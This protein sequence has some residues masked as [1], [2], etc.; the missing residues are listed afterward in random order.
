MSIDGSSSSDCQVVFFEKTPFM[1]VELLDLLKNYKII[2]YDDDSVYRHLKQSWDIGSYLNEDLTKE[3]ESDKAV[4]TMLADQ[5]FLSRVLPDR[6]NVSALF[7]FMNRNIDE[8]LRA[9]K[10][11]MSLAPFQLQES[12]GDKLNLPFICQ[13]LGLPC[14][15]S[16]VFKD[17][18]TNLETA[19][20]KCKERLGVPFVLQGSQ[21]VS[22]EDTF[23]IGSVDDFFEKAQGLQGAF[24]A[25]KYLKTN[26]PISVHL[27]VL[28]K[29]I[30][31][32]GPF[33]QLVGFSELTSRSFA[34]AGNDTNQ[35]L[36]SASLVKAV[37]DMSK[38]IAEYARSKG[39]RG[40]FGVDFLWDKETGIVYVQELNTRLVGLT[41]L[42]TGVQK[43]QG[44]FP[45]IIKHLEEFSEL[46][47]VNE[48]GFL[49]REIDL[50][51]HDY[52]QAIVY[53]NSHSTVTIA[54]YLEP[55]I[56]RLDNDTLQK[57]SFSL[58]VK[59]LKDEEILVTYGA[60]TG[61]ELRPGGM[62]ARI[63]LKR[64]IIINGKYEIE[65]WAGELI[66]S[67]RNYAL[68]PV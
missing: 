11:Q 59:D 58:R 57:M 44:L 31:T 21:G 34:F 7:F 53:N 68:T 66:S 22:G 17:I 23:L 3:L 15:S 47:Y 14:N 12:M 50:S 52:S 38:K 60:H 36:F 41:R 27:T 13:D 24:K 67:V 26:I 43:D 2:T 30:L 28:E 42:L 65:P 61:R 29:Q 4:E 40:I 63:I 6:M 19:F 48:L 10:I 46:N 8:L 51:E 33:L 1:S 64:T 9:A 32:R 16:V 5:G 20:E 37:R 35:S 56:Y 62:I 45:D 39:Y 54:R 55:G 18:E 25:T 49:D